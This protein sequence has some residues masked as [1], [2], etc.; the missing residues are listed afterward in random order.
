MIRDAERKFAF[1]FA[2]PADL[3]DKQSIE[4][5]VE[6]DKVMRAPSDNRELG[7]VFGTFSIR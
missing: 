2:L 6:L 3:V 4:I 1:D 5:T 7:M